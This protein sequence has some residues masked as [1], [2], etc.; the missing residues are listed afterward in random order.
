MT[1]ISINHENLL[2]I[3]FSYCVHKSYKSLVTL[4]NEG[5]RSPC[6]AIL[7]EH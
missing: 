2:H 7:Q 5:S 4:L 1:C 6:E 3:V